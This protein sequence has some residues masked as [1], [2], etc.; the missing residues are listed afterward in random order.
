MGDS[1]QSDRQLCGAEI[2]TAYVSSGS[3]SISREPDLDGGKLTLRM[4]LFA[5][6]AR[7]LIAAP[8]LAAK[9]D[10]RTRNVEP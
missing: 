6:T 2:R 10:G 9:H 4:S 1:I 5:V 7:S 3:V 8:A